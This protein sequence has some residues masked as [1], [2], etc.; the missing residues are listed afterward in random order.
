MLTRE[1]M[2]LMDRQGL[3]DYGRDHLVEIINTAN[4]NGYSKNYFC[5]AHQFALNERACYRGGDTAEVV[6]K[7][8]D[9]KA[10]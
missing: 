10:S 5:L 9:I 8:F 7:V 2:R 4:L 1:Q 6:I 3:F